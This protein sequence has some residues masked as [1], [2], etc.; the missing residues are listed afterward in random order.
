MSQ[1]LYDFV[2]SLSSREKAYFKRFVNVHASGSNKNYL[3]IYDVIEGMKSFR[4]EDLVDHFKGKSIEKYLSSEISYLKNKIL[5]SLINFHGDNTPRNKIQKG[6]LSIEVLI[7]KG[8]RKEAMKKLF[9]YKKISYQQ[10]EFSF[11]LNLIE[12]EENILFK[13]GIFGF[14]DVLKK[15]KEERNL[16]TAAIQ[17]LN[18][19]RILREEIRELQFTDRFITDEFKSQKGFYKNPILQSENSC[20]S[21]KAKAHWYYIQALRYFL[22]RDYHS[23]LNISEKYIRFLEENQNL[24]HVSDQL[25]GISNYNYFAGK[26]GNEVAF[27]KG[28]NKLNNI[29][30]L[31]RIDLTYIKYIKYSRTLS[32]AYTTED[33]SLTEQ[34]LNLSIELIEKEREQMGS[35]QIAFL[36]YLVVRATVVL[37]KYEL[38]AAQLNLM[39]QYD[40]LKYIAIQTRLFSLII[41]YQL[42]WDQL[43][44]SEILLLKSLKKEFPRDKD[45]INSFY[46][47]FKKE[48][49]NPNQTEIH[50]KDL[51]KK[52]EIIKNDKERNFVFEDFDFFEWSRMI[53]INNV[54]V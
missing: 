23:A 39:L 43:L 3:K 53:Y 24:F 30:L 13:E 10:E 20:L 38:G 7:A 44:A 31:P 2:H 34:A 26:T 46:D 41:H 21:I 51:M 48:L 18:D 17:N 11:I 40:V 22:L 45:V 27:N 9:F 37:E 49:K 54:S 47:F 25:P 16:I 5:A 29:S 4:K 12:L 33:K 52:L 14:Q 8:F 6:I 32:M 1:F 50:S 36:L 15:L 19:L 35:V 42:K 28:I